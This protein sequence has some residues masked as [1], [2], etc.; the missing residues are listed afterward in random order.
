MGVFRHHRSVGD[1]RVL[2]HVYRRNYGDNGPECRRIRRN[3]S[4]GNTEQE[5]R[6]GGRTY[7]AEHSGR[8]GAIQV[9]QAS[10]RSDV[11]N[12]TCSIALGSPNRT[13]GNSRFSPDRVTGG[14]AGNT[15]EL[16]ANINVDGRHAAS[17]TRA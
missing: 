2:V 15:R 4:L 12:R 11:G 1:R 7:I 17:S 9:R 6:T 14:G 13:T 5:S 3:S 10:R 8:G 16:G